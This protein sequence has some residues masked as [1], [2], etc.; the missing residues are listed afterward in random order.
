MLVVTLAVTTT[1]LVK[2]FLA[3][4]FG[5]VARFCITVAAVDD[6]IFFVIQH[7]THRSFNTPVSRLT[8][9]LTK[10]HLVEAPVRA[11]NKSCVRCDHCA[12][13]WLG[14]GWDARRPYFCP[15]NCAI[16]HARASAVR[17]VAA[18]AGL[19]HA[20]LLLRGAAR[21]PRVPVRHVLQAGRTLCVRGGV[22]MRACA[23]CRR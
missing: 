2:L 9:P 21:R 1:C 14:M 5:C 10:L 18:T 13:E 12:I 23:R 4:F 6:V 19:E 22:R 8:T 15:G 3:G 17:V 11:R 20:A 7:K 16:A